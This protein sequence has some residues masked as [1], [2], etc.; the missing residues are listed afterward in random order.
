MT[1]L[2]TGF[3]GTSKNDGDSILTRGFSVSRGDN[4]WLGDGVYFFAEDQDMAF[5]W[6][7]GE[8]FKK[9]YNDY[10]I[11]KSDIGIGLKYVFDLGEPDN[12]VQVV[13]DRITRDFSRIPNCIILCVKDVKSC[14]HTVIKG[15]EGA[16]N[17]V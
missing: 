10:V 14:I 11:I 12:F 3:H 4:H 13:R 6:C 5:Q 8:S 16:L 2:T 7:R 17:A 9:K 1:Y 15:K